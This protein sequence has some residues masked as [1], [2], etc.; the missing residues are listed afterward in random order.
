MVIAGWQARHISWAQAIYICK[1]KSCIVNQRQR[2]V[3]QSIRAIRW[4]VSRAWSYGS[5]LGRATASRSAKAHKDRKA[6]CSP[7]SRPRCKSISCYKNLL[8]QNTNPSRNGCALD[9][10]LAILLTTSVL[11]GLRFYLLDPIQQITISRRL[12]RSSKVS[13][14]IDEKQK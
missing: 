8:F 4:E 7:I 12:F 3:I 14:D 1:S 13:P 11:S 2:H 10:C 9:L 6:L 5:S